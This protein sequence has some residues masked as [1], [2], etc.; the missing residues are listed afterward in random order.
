MSEELEEGDSQDTFKDSV[1]S[2]TDTDPME[3]T[4]ASQHTAS[5]EVSQPDRSAASVVSKRW[6]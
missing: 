2:V 3:D 1:L 6:H 4:M 5:T